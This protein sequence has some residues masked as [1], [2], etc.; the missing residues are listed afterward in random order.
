MADAAARGREESGSR[1][2]QYHHFLF[3]SHLNVITRATSQQAGIRGGGGAFQIEKMYCLYACPVDVKSPMLLSFLS[4]SVL[5]CFII[6]NAFIFC[7]Q[8]Q[9]H[10]AVGILLKIEEIH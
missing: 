5:E 8:A 6:I 2:P 9:E 1:P 4:I 3:F 7:A 10:V